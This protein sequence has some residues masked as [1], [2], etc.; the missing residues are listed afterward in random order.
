MFVCSCVAPR[1]PLGLLGAAHK[2]KPSLHRPPPGDL[3]PENV[4]L[5][6]ANNRRGFTA[7]VSSAQPSPESWLSGLRAA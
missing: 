2:E 3:K 1:N 7:K 5:K 6:E 4:L